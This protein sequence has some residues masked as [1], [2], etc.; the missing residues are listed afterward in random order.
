NAASMTVPRDNPAA[1]ILD[2]N[3][4][5]VYGGYTGAVSASTAEIYN[6]SGNSWTFAAGPIPNSGSASQYSR[7]VTAAFHGSG[8]LLTNADSGPYIFDPAAATAPWTQI[9]T[10][11]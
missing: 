4:L 8:K 5:M 3:R 9:N 1:V 11:N 7:G 10:Y 6:A 2:A